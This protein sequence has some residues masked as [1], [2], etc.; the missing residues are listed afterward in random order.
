MNLPPEIFL[1]I[2]QI[3]ILLLIGLHFFLIFKAL[4]HIAKNNSTKSQII[5]QSLMV[6]FIPFSAI[7]YLIFRVNSR[8]Q[9]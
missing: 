4:N 3:F 1:T 6:I 7:S 5:I 9:I 8:S 2:W